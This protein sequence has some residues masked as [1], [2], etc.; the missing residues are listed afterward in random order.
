MLLPNLVLHLPRAVLA[1]EQQVARPRG[2]YEF[3]QRQFCER[4]EGGMAQ[5]PPI[6]CRA[7]WIDAGFGDRRAGKGCRRSRLGVQRLPCRSCDGRAIGIGVR[8]GE[9]I[10]GRMGGTVVEMLLGEASSTA[11]RSSSSSSRSTSTHALPAFPASMSPTSSAGGEHGAAHLSFGSEITVRG[12]TAIIIL[13]EW[14]PARASLADP[15]ESS[16]TSGHDASPDSA[17]TFGVGGS[18]SP[19]P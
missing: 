9:G 6:S 12:S 2:R 11:T 18:I 17:D 14:S 8:L 19:A 7:R 16:P 15:P 13:V 1:I 4:G 10:L 5:Y 3:I